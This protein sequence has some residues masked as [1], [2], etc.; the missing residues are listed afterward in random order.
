MHG[1]NSLNSVD[2]ASQSVVKA[3]ND[4]T[5]QPWLLKVAIHP[6]WKLVNTQDGVRY[7]GWNSLKIGQVKVSYVFRT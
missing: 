7:G 1:V 3:L 4:F 2:E 6:I 5:S